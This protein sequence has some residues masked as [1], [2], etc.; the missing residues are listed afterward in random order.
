MNLAFR[1]VLICCKD[2]VC[3]GIYFKEVSFEYIDLFF[4]AVPLAVPF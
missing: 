2:L 3:P 1:L 4:L